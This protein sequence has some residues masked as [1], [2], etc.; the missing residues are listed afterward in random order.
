MKALTQDQ[1]QFFNENRYL[2]KSDL[3]SA[4]YLELYNT[5]INKLTKKAIAEQ[6]YATQNKLPY[7]SADSYPVYLQ[8]MYGRFPRPRKI[9]QIRGY[10]PDIEPAYAAIQEHVESLIGPA[11]L[12]KD[13]VVLKYPRSPGIGTHSD[14]VNNIDLIDRVVV[15]GLCLTEQTIENGCLE[16][17]DVHAVANMAAAKG[18]DAPC[19]TGDPCV[20]IGDGTREDTYK[21]SKFFKKIETK[22]GDIIFMEGDLLHQSDENRSK[23]LRTIAYTLWNEKAQGD[24][25]AKYYSHM[26]KIKQGNEV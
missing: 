15:V 11:Y 3:V 16:V 24:H 19:M 6:I 21:S 10:L 1:V 4:E 5:C 12:Y 7:S 20:C 9:E 8:S 17:Y 25:Y 14:D 23:K 26:E 13:R 22:P 2:V 18:C